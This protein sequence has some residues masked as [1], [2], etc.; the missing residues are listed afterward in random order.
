MIKKNGVF[1]KLQKAIADPKL[2]IH[3]AHGKLLAMFHQKSYVG[4]K[5]NTRAQSDD[6]LYVRIVQRAVSNPRI[7][8][9]FKRHPH[10]QNI[11][12]RDLPE[13]GVR[14]FSVI[15]NFY[16]E[17]ADS[18]DLF[19]INDS[20]GAPLVFNYPG[21]GQIS[22]NTLRYVK[23]AGHIK[24]IFG[25]CF[26]NIAEIGGG[27][28]GQFLILDQI[29]SFKNYTLFDMLPVTA[30]TQKYLE[31]FV[32]NNAYEIS[33]LNQCS[34]ESCY[35]LVISNF[36]FSELPAPLQRKYIDKVLSKSKR[37]YLTMNSG[38][39][40]SPFNSG[41][42]MIDELKE[43]LPKFEIIEEKPFEVGRY[44]IVWGHTNTGLGN[45]VV[46]PRDYDQAN[47]KPS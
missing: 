44:I 19:K 47:G 6:G 18:I 28:G 23:T 12:G 5:E 9:T 10:Y 1:D 8:H 7:F 4:A 24:S 35:D 37:G 41:K 26:R 38:I 43:L 32:L 11:L 36:A 21:I 2:A 27:Y 31:S 30:L 25:D 39:Y 45:L 17:L 3:Y 33:T 40:S 22:P 29:F 20:V 15:K 42:L 16:P 46:S 34:G 13:D 14:F